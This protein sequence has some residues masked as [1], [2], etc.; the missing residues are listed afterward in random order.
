MGTGYS[1]LTMPIGD[2]ILIPFWEGIVAECVS[3]PRLS[4]ALDPRTGIPDRDGK[5]FDLN[6]ALSVLMN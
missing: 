4:R 6:W 3:C 5:A 1:I 2:R